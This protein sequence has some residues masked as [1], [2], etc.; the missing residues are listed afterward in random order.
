VL[1]FDQ[2]GGIQMHVERLECLADGPAVAP[3]DV[4]VDFEASDHIQRR[5]RA[6]TSAKRKVPAAPLDATAL[7]RAA[8]VF[9]AD[10]WLYE[11]KR[12]HGGDAQSGQLLDRLLAAF[13]LTADADLADQLSG[14]GLILLRLGRYSQFESKAVKVGGVRH[15]VRAGTK[16]KRAELVDTGVTRTVVR[17]AGDVPIPFGW[18]ILAREGHGPAGVVVA[19]VGAFARAAVPAIRPPAARPRAASAPAPSGPA[20]AGMT[21]FKRGDRVTHPSHGDAIVAKDVG[22]NDR[23]IEVDFDGEVDSLPLDGWKRR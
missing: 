17:V 4:Q 19:E 12:F 14:K 21:Q 3:F 16:L 10:L 9:H 22:L 23:K 8:N 5:G 7:W 11:R 18:L 13:H 20:L 15:G 2:T 1:N 6:G